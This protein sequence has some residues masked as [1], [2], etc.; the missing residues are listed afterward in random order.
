MMVSESDITKYIYS[1]LQTTPKLSENY[2][3]PYGNILPHRSPYVKIKQFIDDFLNSEKGKPVERWL[4]LPGL[5]GTGKTTLIFQMY[6]YLRTETHVKNED[7][8]YLSA[9]DVRT[10]LDIGIRDIILY[11]LK[12]IHRTTPV[13]LDKKIFI[14]IDE[15]HFD[16]KWEETIK[17]LYDR[18][19]GNDNLFFVVT[20]SSSI[21]LEMS[22][23][24]VRRRKKHSI[25]PMNLQEYIKLKYKKFPPHGTS[26]FIR[27]VIFNGD[28]ISFNNHYENEKKLFR[29]MTELP[30]PLD[31][32]L[33]DFI[34]HGGFP[35]A[36][37]MDPFLIY[38]KIAEL[39]DKIICD[40]LSLIY[41]YKTGSRIDIT[42]ILIF[43]ALKLAG[44]VSQPK[45]S[46]NL[47][48]PLA[49]VN[50]TLDALE[51]THLLF[52]LKPYEGPSGMIRDAWKYYFLSSTIKASLLHKYGRLD[53]TD[54]IMFGELVENA[55]ISAFFRMM[56]TID[57][58]TGIFYDP[59]KGGVDFLLTYGEKV[60]PVEVCCGKKDK[61]QTHRTSK[62][63][64]KVKH[65]IIISNEEKSKQEDDVY[66]IPLKTFLF[67]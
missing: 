9:S 17:M 65:K 51:K 13:N 67:S 29:K 37:N 5:R 48:I 52:S 63:I 38:E 66:Y 21:S 12:E 32:E 27:N 59:G 28:E 14:F 18:T 61:K 58:P 36:I 24:S 45:L 8:L 60:I 62:R 6:D 35:F 53:R 50:Q 57:K 55:V 39:V 7:F 54:N 42:K 16:P 15:A 47:Q 31:V 23:D 20:G 26:E 43:L 56:K 19:V 41:H 25:L 11:Y 40:D 4:V 49:R 46:R 64:R 33:K 22:T 3:M 34:F 2:I 44:E 10:Y 1:I 30:N